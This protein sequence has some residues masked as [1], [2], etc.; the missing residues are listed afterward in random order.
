MPESARRRSRPAVASAD[1]S[2]MTQNRTLRPSYVDVWLVP[3]TSS[4]VPSRRTCVAR[5]WALSLPSSATSAA[6]PSEPGAR[7]SSRWRPIS[8]SRAYP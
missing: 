2:V 6:I 7:I 4:N 8:S 3:S 1:T 5:V